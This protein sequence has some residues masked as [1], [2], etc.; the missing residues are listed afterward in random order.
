MQQVLALGL[1]GNIN[2][3]RNHTGLV[4]CLFINFFLTLHG[5]VNVQF[6]FFILVKHCF[7]SLC[8]CE[9]FIV[10]LRASLR[11]QAGGGGGSG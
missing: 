4:C 2:C 10:V 11:K 8:V 5:W 1:T 9:S 6:E 3:L 7:I